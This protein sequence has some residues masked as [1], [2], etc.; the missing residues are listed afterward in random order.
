MIYLIRV[1]YE[2]ETLLKIGYTEDSRKKLRYS[3]YKMHNP[4]YEL[5]NEIP[6]GD[7]QDETNLHYKFRHLLKYGREWFSE[8]KE[9]YEFFKSHTTKESLQELKP[10]FPSF[11]RSKQLPIVNPYVNAIVRVLGNNMTPVDINNLRED[12]IDCVPELIDGYIQRLFPNEFN[13][14]IKAYKDLTASNSTPE[15]DEFNSLARFDDRMMLVV[16]KEKILSREDY[17]TFLTR[18]PAEYRNYVETLGTD[19]IRAASYQRSK[20]FERWRKLVSIDSAED[21][22]RMRVYTEFEVGKRYSNLQTK[23]ILNE[24]YQEL[25]YQKTPKAT[26]LE[27]YFEVKHLKV[28]IDGNRVNGFEIIK[29]L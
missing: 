25:E 7:L 5:L 19:E 29:Q 15:L 22:V 2:K 27:N 18:I 26:D 20:I 24:I 13:E 3:N 12:L 10:Y 23:Q 21:L 8:S 17:I 1:K 11:I 28:T 9:I 4:L 6:E 14:I 16:D